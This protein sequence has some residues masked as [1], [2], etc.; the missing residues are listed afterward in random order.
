MEPNVKETA[1]YVALKSLRAA[2]GYIGGFVSTFKYYFG[3]TKDKR[4]R[5]KILEARLVSFR[6]TS[7]IL[8]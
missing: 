7:L 2:S 4:V 3:Q 5:R 6:P 8:S 1:R